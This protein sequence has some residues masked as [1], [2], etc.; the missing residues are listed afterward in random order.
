MQSTQVAKLQYLSDG[1]DFLQVVG[2]GG[3][4]LYGVNEKGGSQAVAQKLTATGALSGRLPGFY[5]ITAGSAA[6]ITVSAPTA[7][8]DD[9]LEIEISSSTNFAHVIVGGAGT[10]QMGQAAGAQVT[11]PAFA[12]A[13]VY[14]TAFN[15]KWIVCTG[16]N[17]AYTV[18]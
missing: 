8:V 13:T 7:G 9:G 2:Q 10:I 6:T 4:V 3:N 18:A 16:G 15:G 11:L 17:G 1:T 5:V 14:M 12:G